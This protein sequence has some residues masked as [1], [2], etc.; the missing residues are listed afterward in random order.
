VPALQLLDGLV[1]TL[2][3]LV[4]LQA[5]VGAMQAVV[6]AAKAG[7]LSEREGAELAAV[8]EGLQAAAFSAEEGLPARLLRRLAA[9]AR[10]GAGGG[11]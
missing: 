4:G 5:E 11:G 1:Q 10:G 9:L 8:H 3:P 6:A 7:A 2:A